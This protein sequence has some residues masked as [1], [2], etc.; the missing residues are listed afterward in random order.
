MNVAETCIVVV[1]CSYCQW[2]HLRWPAK[3]EIDQDE[4]VEC[5]NCI[6]QSLPTDS[7]TAPD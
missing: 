1:L 2:S 6:R 3:A 4:C 5:N 7:L